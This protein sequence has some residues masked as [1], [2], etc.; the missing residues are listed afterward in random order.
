[1]L[2]KEQLVGMWI[3]VPSEWNEDGSFDEKTFREEIA[4][5]IDAGAHGLYTTGSTGEF[6]ALDWEDWK[7]IQDA[8]IAETAG[9][10][11]VQ[12]GA[13]WFNTRD[14]IK[15]VRYARDIGADAVQICFPGWMEMRQEDYDQFLIDVYEAVPDIAIIHYNTQ[16]TK[17]LFLAEDYLRILPQVPTIIG[18]KALVPFNSYIELMTRVPEINHF[19]RDDLFSLA[20]PLGGKG[21]Y[22]SWFMMNPKFFH[23]YYQQC[24][25]GNYAEALSP[26]KRLVRW[27]MEALKPLLDRGYQDPTLDK[28][29]VAMSGWLPGN[30]HTRKPYSPLSEEEFAQL[31]QATEQVIPEFLEFKP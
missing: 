20:A 18:T 31:R 11:P 22:S 29:F 21:T 9:K 8:F 3:S 5:L 17:K 4:M 2:T 6:H 10:I 15:R 24:L 16:R 1:M 23:D 25:G 7:E 14:T 26:T 27:W 12:V 13:N 28:A 30:R 19:C